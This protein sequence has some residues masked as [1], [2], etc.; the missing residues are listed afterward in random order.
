MS[1]TAMGD[2]SVQK[3]WIPQAPL[4]GTKLPSSR[5]PKARK[6]S[7]FP[8]VPD[9]FWTTA[10]SWSSEQVSPSVSNP[11]PKSFKRIDLDSSHPSSHPVTG[12]H[13]QKLWGHLSPALESW[14]RMPGVELGPLAPPGGPPHPRYP[15]RFLTVTQG[16]G[17]SLFCFS[18]PPTSLEVTSSVWP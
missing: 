17:I 4:C 14:A 13:T 12:F 15:S 5:H 6:R 8:Y 9:I 3:Q 11:N 16:S 7:S 10:Q 2:A 1:H 18:A